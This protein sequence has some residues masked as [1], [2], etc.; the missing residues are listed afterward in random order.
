MRQGTTPWKPGPRAKKLESSD[1]TSP[2]GSWGTEDRPP[3]HACDPWC[4][5]RLVPRTGPPPLLR[6]GLGLQSCIPA[7]RSGG[8]RTG[9]GP[10]GDPTAHAS[11]QLPVGTP[12]PRS[13][14]L[15]LGLHYLVVKIKEV[16]VFLPHVR[17]RVR[18]KLPNVPVGQ[19]GVVRTRHPGT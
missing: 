9:T 3:S 14:A 1:P 18:D 19:G 7:P 2:R 13:H 15:P 11:A 5:R 12:T 16:R 6:G 17:F 4:T 10:P 8:W